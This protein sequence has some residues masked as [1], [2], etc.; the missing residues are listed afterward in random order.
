MKREPTREKHQLSLERK[1]DL[2][3][4]PKADDLYRLAWDYGHSSGWSEIE[5]YY[6][7]LL[8]LLTKLPIARRKS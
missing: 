4:H 6:V 1:Y 2:L 8:D 5:N 7:E 3:G